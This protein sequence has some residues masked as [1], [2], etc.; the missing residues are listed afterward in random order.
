MFLVLKHKSLMFK[1]DIGSIKVI[2]KAFYILLR[3]RN[4]CRTTL[5]IKST[6]H[7][8]MCI[9]RAFGWFICMFYTQKTKTLRNASD[10]LFRQFI[11]VY[12]YVKMFVV[13]CCVLSSV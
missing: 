3:P 8:I 12:Y 11:R 4:W 1:I 2:N 10:I 13:L 7:Y 6:Y 9:S 5:L